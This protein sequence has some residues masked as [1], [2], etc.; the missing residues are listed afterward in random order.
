MPCSLVQAVPAQARG[1]GDTQ[2]PG[3]H[4]QL[5]LLLAHVCLRISQAQV[6]AWFPI[7]TLLNHSCTPNLDF[8]FQFFDLPDKGSLPFGAL[9]LVCRA[10]QRIKMVWT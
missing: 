3:L 9:R 10:N 1:K 5:G 8:E 6:S 4:A 7:A 2:C